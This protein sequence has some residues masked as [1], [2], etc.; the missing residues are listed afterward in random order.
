VTGRS[1]EKH[2]IY[3]GGSKEQFGAGNAFMFLAL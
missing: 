2:L 1:E 3:V